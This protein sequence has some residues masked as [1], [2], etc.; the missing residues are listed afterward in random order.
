MISVCVPAYENPDSLTRTLESV[1]CQKDCI[2]EIIITDDSE[3]DAVSDGVKKFLT[4]KRIKYIKNY[5]R[6]GAVNNWNY[7]LSQAS[8]KVKKLLH[9]DDWLSNE[10][11]LIEIATPILENEADIVFCAC[12]AFG[13]S[14]LQFVHE[15]S[16]A[17]EHMLKHEPERLVFGN[18][19]GAPSVSAMSADINV[20]FDPKYLWMS[21][22]DFYIR[23]LKVPAIRL[24]IINAAL[25]CISTEIETQITRAFE[26]DQRSSVMELIAL[27]DREYSFKVFDSDEDKKYLLNSLS[28]FSKQKE[29]DWLFNS[30]F[31]KSWFESRVLLNYILGRV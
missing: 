1:I 26:K 31:N 8:G 22:V 25:I 15:I 29:A 16:H 12:N 24:K 18:L 7:A 2:F 23:C 17:T 19:V 20:S 21:D 27:V 3:T 11:S 9:H 30:I 28:G 6:L 5:T 4:D 13:M 14:G 10:Y